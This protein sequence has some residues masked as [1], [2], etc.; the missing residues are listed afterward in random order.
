MARCNQRTVCREKNR[1][2][3]RRSSG[4]IS[5][6]SRPSKRTSAV[7]TD[8]ELF[9]SRWESCFWEDWSWRQ[10]FFVFLSPGASLHTVVLNNGGLVTQAATDAA[11]N[12]PKQ[13]PIAATAVALNDPERAGR[14]SIEGWQLWQKQQVDAAAA[15]FEEAV[16]LDPKN[17]GTGTGWVGL[18]SAGATTGR[19][20]RP[21][22]KSSRWSRHIRRRSTDWAKWHLSAQ[23]RAGRRV[24]V[25]SGRSGA[26]G[27]LG[28]GQALPADRQVR[29]GGQMGGEDHP[30]G[31]G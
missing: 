3:M 15:K 20:K 25:E 2:S 21:S 31:R 11:K 9:L 1:V 6:S 13:G 19:R 10:S 7:A 24:S 22:A 14:L 8:I 28:P 23:I 17:V 5:C 30:I 16:K 29:Q 4:R 18:P 27:P 12:S 26:G